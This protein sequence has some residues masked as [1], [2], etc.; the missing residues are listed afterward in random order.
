MWN[1]SINHVAW[2]LD[3]TILM[4]R[5]DGCLFRIEISRASMPHGA[6]AQ[7]LEYRGD[8]YLLIDNIWLRV[9]STKP[10]SSPQM[11]QSLAT[12]WAKM[13]T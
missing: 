4:D 1:V 8:V 12:D 3:S 9:H 7:L 2:E 13:F 11:V 10:Q 6:I 5:D